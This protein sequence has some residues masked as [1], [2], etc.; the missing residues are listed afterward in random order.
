M[1]IDLKI[2]FKKHT[3]STLDESR[4]KKIE[5][6]K[7]I[8]KNRYK[9][10][11]FTIVKIDVKNRLRNRFKKIKLKNQVNKIELKNRYKKIDLKKSI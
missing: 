4:F 10:I 8:C 3:K 9:I 11:D 6:T 5:L 7:S 1:K 2:R